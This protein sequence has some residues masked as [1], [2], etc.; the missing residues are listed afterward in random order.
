LKVLKSGV[1]MTPQELRKVKGGS[2]A[3]GCEGGYSSSGLFMSSD[4]SGGCYC[5]CTTTYPDGSNVFVS[6]WSSA[7][8]Y[9]M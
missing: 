4:G 1:E 7:Y 5:G 9:M 8:N 2:C 6:P 3:C